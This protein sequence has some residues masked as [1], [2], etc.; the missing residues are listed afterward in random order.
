MRGY[1]SKLWFAR[2]ERQPTERDE[3]CDHEKP[4]KPGRIQCLSKWQPPAEYLWHNTRQT[5]ASIACLDKDTIADWLS[6]LC[7]AV[8]NILFALNAK[9]LAQPGLLIQRQ[10]QVV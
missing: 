2:P 7:R 1:P 5:L 9:D 4:G 10:R 3:A 6:C 8:R